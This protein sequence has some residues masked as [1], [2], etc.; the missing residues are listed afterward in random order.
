M[1]ECSDPRV[2]EA[3]RLLSE[4]GRLDI[5][6]PDLKMSNKPEARKMKA[7][8]GLLLA[9]CVLCTA[10]AQDPLCTTDELLNSTSSTCY[11][12]PSK[13]TVTGLKASSILHASIVTHILGNREV[14]FIEYKVLKAKKRRV[15]EE[16]SW[17]V[18]ANLAVT[19]IG[20][21]KFY[22][23]QYA[24]DLVLVDHTKVGLQKAFNARNTYYI[25]D[26]L[27]TNT[28]TPPDPSLQCL[29]GTM[30]LSMS[31][32]QLEKSAFDWDNLHLLDPACTGVREVNGTA[33]VVVSTTTSS[34]TCGNIL[35]LS[36]DGSSVIYSNT[37][38][39]PG[40]VSLSGILSRQNYTYN[41]SCSYPLKNIPASLLTAMHPMVS[42]IETTL[43]TGSGTV[44]VLVFAF[45]DAGF[46]IPYTESTTL[47]VQAPLYIGVI[48]PD[49]DAD[50]FSLRVNRLFATGTSNATD[51]PQ[52]DLITSGCPDSQN[53]DLVTIDQNGN[54][55]DARFKVSVFKIAAS[56]VLYFHASVEICKGTCTPDEEIIAKLQFEI[57]VVKKK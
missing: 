6:R 57:F 18:D 49:L 21:S 9:L 26:E 53:G 7:W 50:G 33:Q 47:Q 51:L 8:L 39:I 48:A 5:V 32:C 13:Y 11:C 28:K 43:P 45:V 16:V 54:S 24:D 46:T 41:Y 1:A 40:K 35:S 4:A 52:F 34:T 42:L 20:E 12:D 29:S 44:V 2:A 37:L 10:V 17:K 55:I 3:L 14:Q 30:R 15:A 23:M 25:K 56:D 38:T 22:R 27:V 36:A 31:K 19:R